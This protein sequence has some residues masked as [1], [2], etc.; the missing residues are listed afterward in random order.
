MYKDNK[1]EPKNSSLDK[2]L[3]L[4]SFYSHQKDTLGLSELSRLSGIPKA[5]VYRIL[6]TMVDR[7]YLLKVDVMGKESQY[8]LGYKFLEL[9]NIVSSNLELKAVAKPYMEK[10]KKSIN[11]SS[12]IVVKSGNEAIYIEK[13]ECDRP[14]K[15]YT[16]VGKRAPLYAGACPRAILSFLP[17]EEIYNILNSVELVKYA[18]NTVTDID[19]IWKLIKEARKLGYTISYSELADETFAIG[20]P[21]RDHKGDVIGSLSIV[22]PESRLNEKTRDLYISE[23]L[24]A[25][26]EISASLGYHK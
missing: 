25:A 18:K 19:E 2:A 16:A 3:Y 21:I 12:Q 13:L 11:E 23:V 5:T 17:D 1:N 14:V 9:G 24:K 8:K 7:G 10:I 20:A 26:E 4:L 22:G 15:A 6:S